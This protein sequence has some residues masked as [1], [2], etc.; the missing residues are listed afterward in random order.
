[1]KETSKIYVDL[2]S[3]LDIR[4]AI[5][6]TL[7]P[8]QDKLM[9]YLDSEEYNFRQTDTFSIVNSA[10]YDVAYKSRSTDLLPYST[11]THT[12]ISLK[13]KLANLEKRNIYYG[14]TKTPEIVLNI[15]PFTLTTEQT[16]QIQNLLFVKLETNTLVTVVSISPL[17]LSPYFIKNGSFT[18]CFIYNFSEWMNFHSKSLEDNKLTDT[19]LYFPAIYVS[20]D[21]KEQEKIVK[22]GFKDVFNYTEFLLSSVA[23]I[24]FLPT[25]FYSNLITAS[26]YLKKFNQELK[27]TDLTQDSEKI[28]GDSI[29]EV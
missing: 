10:D 15:Y 22:L 23:N 19:I 2:E 25:V 4:Q 18:A 26:R 3:L 27:D 21:E 8:D 9:T 1:M 20:Y 6:Y 28:D 14:E 11:I 12:L 24:N 5:L 7:Y 17:E 13:T 29:P 16:E